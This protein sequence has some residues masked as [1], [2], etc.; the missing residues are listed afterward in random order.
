MFL[1]ALP[2]L[3]Q[4]RA[5]A[6]DRLSDSQRAEYRQLLRGYIDAFRIFGRSRI[7]KLDFEADAHFREV[8]RRHGED[9]EAVRIVRLA[10]TSGAENLLMDEAIYPKPPSPMPCDVMVYMRG[11]GIPPLP[12]SL[13]Q[14]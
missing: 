8:A 3:A 10:Y 1:P 6:P 2:V 12:A 14:R 13:M 5:L 7:C 11:L 9:S 4:D